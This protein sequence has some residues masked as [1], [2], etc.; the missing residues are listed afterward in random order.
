MTCEARASAEP[1]RSPGG[2]P[3]ANQEQDK[4]KTVTEA[5]SE[6]EEDDEEEED[7]E[8][9]EDEEDEEE[10]EEEEKEAAEDET[11]SV[12]WT[13]EDDERWKSERERD[14]YAALGLPTNTAD[15]AAVSTSRVRASYHRLSQKWHPRGHHRSRE[16]AVSWDT[17]GRK[18][19]LRMF[20]LIT[21]AYLVLKDPERRRIYDE[22]GFV[23]LK[24]SEACY[25][26]SIFEQDAFEVFDA[27]FSGTD[28]E[29]REFLLMNG[30][31][32]EDS[33][34]SESED[35]TWAEAGDIMSGKAKQLEH[36]STTAAPAKVE[37]ELPP[38]VAEALSSF[39]DVAGPAALEERWRSMLD[40]VIAPSEKHNQSLNASVSGAGPVLDL[41]PEPSATPAA[42]ST[43]TTAAIQPELDDDARAAVA[44]ATSLGTA[45]CTAEE[46]AA[47]ALEKEAHAVAV[48][49]AAIQPELDDDAR[50][51]VADATSLG[52]ARCTAEEEAAP[53]L[54][55]EA[56]AVAVEPAE[57][58]GAAFTAN[59]SPEADGAAAS[60]R[61]REID[62]L[63]AEVDVP[64]S[65]QQKV[66][67]EPA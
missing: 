24:Q 15:R 22:C 13:A 53:A 14:Y 60:P 54:E 11:E 63:C 43:V 21:E 56:H 61:K 10:E 35:E 65:K 26:E 46:E 40:S 64:L 17:A 19:A 31:P 25:E 52:I 66:E 6:S 41:P 38:E 39:A 28:P 42:S 49:T 23:G 4:A 18:E 67:V 5:A 32:G 27:F 34:E 20:W 62:A 7:E 2:G 30:G 55:K 44:D 58:A 33:E 37:P 16:H 47:P 36:A 50:A 51:A 9:D 12:D 8:N 3:K 59:V 45:K 57:S 1:A 48:T 29:D